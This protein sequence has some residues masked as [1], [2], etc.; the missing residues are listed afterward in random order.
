MTRAFEIAFGLTLTALAGFIDALGFIRLGG[1]YTSFMSGNTTR[2]SVA[3]GQGAWTLAAGP[4]VLIATF[5]VGAMLGGGLAG[6]T[7]PR[8]RTACVLGFEA[9]LLVAALAMEI[10]VPDHA[11]AALFMALAMGA[12]NAALV[13]VGGFR[14]GTTFV[15]GALYGFGQ[16]LGLALAGHGPAFGWVPDGAVW[17]ALLSGAVAGTVAYG[18]SPLYALCGA[19]ATATLLAALAGGFAL[20]GRQ[21]VDPSER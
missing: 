5:A 18:V 7:S 3:L 2:M 4:A 10:T 21:V 19:V 12:Q 17:L 9:L 20:A 6:L 16:K 1:L 15:T 13:H 14:A 11:V 8:W